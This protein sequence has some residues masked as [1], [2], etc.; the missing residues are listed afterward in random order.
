[1]SNRVRI[2]RININL[3]AFGNASRSDVDQMYSSYDDDF[4][5]ELWAHLEKLNPSKVEELPKKKKKKS[6]E[7]EE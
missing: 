3:D 5:D 6:K 4:R 1:M 2:G 7:G